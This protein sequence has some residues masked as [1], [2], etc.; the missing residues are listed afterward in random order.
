MN[1]KQVVNSRENDEY[2]DNSD[3][4]EGDYHRSQQVEKKEKEDREKMI[5]NQFKL[6]KGVWYSIF[7]T[8]FCCEAVSSLLGHFLWLERF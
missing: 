1:S 5:S 2:A 4:D 7:V 3:G 6:R 8:S